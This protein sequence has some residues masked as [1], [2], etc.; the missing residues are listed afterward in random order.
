MCGR[1]TLTPEP[2]EILEA[3]PGLA[4]PPGVV[5][6]Y[7]VAPSNRVLAVT[8]TSGQSEFEMLSWGLVPSWAKDAR[9]ANSLVNARADSVAH[10]P[11]FRAAF[12]ARRCLVVAD[13][14]YEWRADGRRKRPYYFRLGGGRVFAFAGLWETWAGGSV[15]LRSCTLITTDANAVVAPIHHRMPVILPPAAYDAWLGGSTPPDALQSL[16]VPYPAEEMTAWEVSSRV[17]SPRN[18]SPDCIAPLDGGDGLRTTVET[19]ELF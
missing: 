6:R 10:K 2:S 17:S 12:R 18:D 9:I 5:A 11:A 14:F 15:P 7:N 13:G 3:F 8:N 16:L 1:F 19:L 4:L